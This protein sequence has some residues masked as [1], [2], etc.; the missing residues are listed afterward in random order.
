MKK[1]QFIILLFLIFP[2]FAQGQSDTTNLRKG[3]IKIFLDCNYC[4]EEYIKD[5][6]SFVNYVRDTKEAQVHVLIT[7]QPSGNGGNLYTLFFMGQQ[8]FQAK[9]DTLQFNTQ[10]DNSADEILKKEVKYLKMGLI[11]YAIHSPIGSKISIDFKINENKE[12]KIVEDK[13]KSWV[14]GLTANGWFN[15]ESNYKQS[16]IYNEISASKITNDFKLEFELENSINRSLFIIGE[17]SIESINRSYSFDNRF[18]KSINSHWSVGYSYDI[19]SSSYRNLE[20]SNKFLPGIEYNFFPYKDATTKQ[21]RF[22]LSAG[23]VYNIYNDTTIY[24]K[25]SEGLAFSSL[26]IALS[27]KKKWGS[28]SSSLE[29][30]SYLPDLTKNNLELYNSLSIRIVKGLSIRLNGSVE[31]VHDQI[32]LPKGGASYEDVLLQQQQLA[33]QYNYWGSVGLSYTFGSIYNNVVNPRFGF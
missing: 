17:D 2:I 16:N 13:W 11:P 20:L 6:I 32:S 28:I 30:S 22:L 18:V 23:Y 26:E 10:A 9:N 29:L 5:H 25:I 15:G 21:L 33:T 1:L 8:N 14:F 27:I 12:D 4:D 31:F 19:S 24:N 3:A 7:S